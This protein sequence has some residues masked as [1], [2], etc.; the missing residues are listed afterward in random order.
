MAKALSNNIKFYISSNG[1]VLTPGND[2]GYLEPKYFLRVERVSK[3]VKPV[4]GWEG[5][6]DGGPP[7]TLFPEPEPVPDPK[8]ELESE[9][10]TQLQTSSR[11]Q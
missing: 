9:S 10:T 11:T 3:R 1:V 2:V 8:P 6:E 7:K 5:K 4:P